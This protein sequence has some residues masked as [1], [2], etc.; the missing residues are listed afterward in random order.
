MLEDTYSMFE[1][2]ASAEI[3]NWRQINRNDLFVECVNNENNSK[4]YSAY[5]AA[6]ICT[7]RSKLDTLYYQSQPVFSAEDCY[8]WIV[9]SLMYT[10]KHRKWLDPKSSLYNDPKG[11]DKAFNIC[12]K[13]ER[14]TAYQASNRYKR[15][16]NALTY[17]IDQQIE[18]L[19]DSV[20]PAE[21]YDSHADDFD[22]LVIRAFIVKD[23]FKAFTLDLILHENVFYSVLQNDEV[24]TEFSMKRLLH[25]LRQLKEP[26]FQMFSDKYKFSIEKV[27]KAYTYCEKLQT[28]VYLEKVNRVL[29]ELK[30]ELKGVIKK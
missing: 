17:S 10:I 8:D 14:L 5:L 7:Y 9:T 4:L 13:S 26:Y 29:Q 11:P 25:M 3:P 30:R 15:K 19:G 28:D 21:S 12:L 16:I 1:E 24:L 6:L 20:T 27:R 22:Y 18:D 23:Y 2:I